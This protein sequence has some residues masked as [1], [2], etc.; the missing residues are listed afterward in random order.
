[1]QWIS[2]AYLSVVSQRE[3]DHV[4]VGPETRIRVQRNNN[5][6]DLLDSELQLLPEVAAAAGEDTSAIGQ[7][8]YVGVL[9]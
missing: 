2:W 5:I 9:A 6:V 3:S 1:M 4:R 8:G 7:Y